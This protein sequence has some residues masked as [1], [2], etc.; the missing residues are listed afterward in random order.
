MST[1]STERWAKARELY[2]QG[3]QT[4]EGLK[5][6]TYEEIS[7]ECGLKAQTIRAK[8]ARENWTLQR[9]QFV[10]KVSDLTNEKKSTVMVGESVE[11][12]SICLE[13]ARK[14]IDRVDRGLE[15]GEPVEKMAS[16]LEKAQKVGKLA[17]GENPEADKDVTINVKYDN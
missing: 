3:R 13:K 16:A 8:A 9:K 14:I 2:I 11:F 1:K 4:V 7:K 17:F 15:S 12:D 10:K 6:P 5:Y